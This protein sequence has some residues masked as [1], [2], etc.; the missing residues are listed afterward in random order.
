[1]RGVEPGIHFGVWRCDRI[2]TSQKYR[3]LDA[4]VWFVRA[5]PGLN[6]RAG[7]AAVEWRAHVLYERS[8][9]WFAEVEGAGNGTTPVDIS[10]IGI[11]NLCL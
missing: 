9:E 2:S 4:R 5:I 1:M 7:G 10:D 8:Y 3:S 11:I 6:H